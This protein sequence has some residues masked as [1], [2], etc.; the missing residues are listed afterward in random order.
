VKEPEPELGVG[1]P[2]GGVEVEADV[3]I[4]AADAVEGNQM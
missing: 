4:S 1:V 2:N 3:G